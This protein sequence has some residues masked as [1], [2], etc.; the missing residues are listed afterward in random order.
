MAI[1]DSDSEEEEE[2]DAG[3]A[4]VA[5]EQGAPQAEDKRP[6]RAIKVN[7]VEKGDSSPLLSKLA[8]VKLENERVKKKGSKPK[9]EPATAT[10]T[11][12]S[13][14][15]SSSSSSGGNKGSSVPTPASS[16]AQTGSKVLIEE[17]AP[18][19]QPERVP[20]EQTK[21]P[22]EPTPAAVPAA[23]VPAAA[24]APTTP[25]TATAPKTSYEIEQLWRSTKGDPVKFAPHILA[26]EPTS[27]PQV[28]KES[29]ESDILVGIGRAMLHAFF[30]QHAAR[31]R[32]SLQSWV[33][34]PRFD[35]AVMF[36]SA[37]DKAVIGNV[38]DAIDKELGSG[39]CAQLRPK[40]DL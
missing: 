9:A 28:F 30:P 10:T 12:T 8:A 1:V 17:V 23:A 33:H 39:T 18:A 20:V 22:S 36:M 13:S 4:V 3:A 27:Y 15:S 16:G 21:E 40:F 19:S 29:L 34:I 32:D 37:D 6:R 11:T 38:C 25:T 24:A 2:G 31:A 5:R 14:S 26:I 7:M 35:M